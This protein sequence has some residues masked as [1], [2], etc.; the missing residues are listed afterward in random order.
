MLAEN[1]QYRLLTRLG[2]L[3]ERHIKWAGIKLPKRAIEKT[4]KLHVFNHTYIYIMLKTKY[5]VEIVLQ[6]M[7]C[8]IVTMLLS[9]LL[10]RT[11][12]RLLALEPLD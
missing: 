4:V 11:T 8:C 2:S 5:L 3:N 1:N 9:F 10:Q 6:S 7:T 12:D